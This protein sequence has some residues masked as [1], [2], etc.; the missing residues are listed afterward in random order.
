MEKA[1]Q[2]FPNSIGLWKGLIDLHILR[3]NPSRARAALD[4]AQHSN[5]KNVELALLGVRL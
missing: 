3:K 4:K 1:T 2:F 5:P